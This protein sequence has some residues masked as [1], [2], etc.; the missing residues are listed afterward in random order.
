MTIHVTDYSLNKGEGT[1]LSWIQKLMC[2][3]FKIEPLIKHHYI[4]NINDHCRTPLVAGHVVVGACGNQLYALDGN[5]LKTTTPLEH[6]PVIGDKI[7][8]LYSTYAG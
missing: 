7:T 6:P 3:W 5:T 8:I 2:K 4:I 1:R